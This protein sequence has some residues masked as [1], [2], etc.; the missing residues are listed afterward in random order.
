M[1]KLATIQQIT[2]ITP[3]EGKDKIALEQILGWQ[4]IIQ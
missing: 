1:R 4:V 2:D 3:I